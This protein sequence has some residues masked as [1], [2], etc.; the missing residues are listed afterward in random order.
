MP[1]FFPSIW[2]G[3]FRAKVEFDR[4]ASQLAAAFSVYDWID[5]RLLHS[6]HGFLYPAFC[7]ACERVTQMRVN[8][9]FGGW[10]N[11]TPSIH[12]AWTE[13]SVCQ[14]CGLNSRMRALLDFLK[15]NHILRN[16]RRAYIAEQITPFYRILKRT[17]PSLIGSEYCGPGRRSGSR[18]FNWRY[19]QWVRHEDLTNLSF[20]DNEFDLVVTLDVFEHIHDYRK[21]FAEIHRVLCPA[22]WLVFTIPFF[23]DLATTRIRAS[24][25][26]DGTITH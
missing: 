13:T 15:T 24:V 19:L 3:E 1:P 16:I 2:L 8:W 22:G 17:I 11:V 26:S 4:V 14:R 12:P 18:V 9:L 6:R 23:Y 10:S 20:A 21:A 5:D 25:N 7:S